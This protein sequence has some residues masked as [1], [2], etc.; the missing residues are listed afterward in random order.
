MEMSTETRMVGVRIMSTCRGAPVW[1][2]V[3]RG[4]VACLNARV[5]IDEDESVSGESRV[6]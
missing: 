4:R 3:G 2:I 5:L 1:S 6:T